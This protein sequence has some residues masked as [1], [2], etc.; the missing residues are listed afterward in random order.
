M[1]PPPSYN[2][3]Q[4]NAPNTSTT[5][6]INTNFSDSGQT[7]TSIPITTI[8][9]GE[10]DDIPPP[11]Y[12]RSDTSQTI[13]EPLPSYRASIREEPPSSSSSQPQPFIVLTVDEERQQAT[14]VAPTR[15]NRAWGKWTIF[16][17]IIIIIPLVSYIKSRN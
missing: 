8:A 2:I 7:S 3:S 12:H 10:D 14:P 13:D 16:L 9:L 15:D 4:S 6:N 11:A 1:S 17:A 5:A